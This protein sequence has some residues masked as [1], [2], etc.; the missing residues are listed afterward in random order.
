M[1]RRSAGVWRG[2]LV[3]I[4]LVLAAL[5]TLCAAGLSTYV[6]WSLTHPAKK[7]L[8]ETPSDYG[9]AYEKIS[10]PSRDGKISLK[11]W[12]LPGAEGT[13]G[14]TVIIAHG[15][16]KN[17]LQDDAHIMPLVQSIIKEGYGVVM[18]DFRNSG[19]SGGSL[20]SVGEYEEQDLLGAID[21]VKQ[22]HP[23]RTA[24]LGFSM[25]ASTA[26]LAAAEEPSVASVIADSPFSHLERY[27][28]EN[29]PAWSHLPSFPFT[30]LILGILPPLV[31]VHPGLVDVSAAADAV[32]PRPVLFIHSKDDDKIPSVNSQSMWQAHPD[33]FEFWE[34]KQAGHVGSYKLF[35]KAYTEKV[36]QFLAGNL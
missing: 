26:L 20:T 18:F 7:P 4:T 16:S 12:F 28:K 9:L 27:L 32:Y 14:K 35:P 36:L 21:W 19:E 31:G 1:R 8:T 13:G 2:R 3:R 17:R 22:E 23:G 33:K 10:F 29:L 15:Y 11:G 24:L 30:P 25:G 6:G 5:L 34:T